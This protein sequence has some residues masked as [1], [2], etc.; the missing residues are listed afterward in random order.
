MPGELSESTWTGFV[1]KH[2]LEVDDKALV[3]AL[4]AYDKTDESKP[5]P[6]LKALDEVVKQIAEQVKALT[7][8]KK[9]LGDKPFGL[10]CAKARRGCTP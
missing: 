1:K 10:A 8:R 9:E 4:V 2:K 5:D 6:R 3:K 7:K